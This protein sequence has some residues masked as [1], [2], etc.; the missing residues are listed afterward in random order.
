MSFKKRIILFTALLLFWFALSGAIDQR[1]ILLGSL[2]A[3]ASLL[4]YEWI[5][6]HSKIKPLP[7]MPSVRWL[8]LVQITI[9]AIITSTY[10]HIVRIFYGDDETVFLQI[11][12][13][14]NHPYVTTIIANVIT[15]TPGAVSVE[16]DG[17]ILK[18]LMFAPK[19]ENERGKIY[20]LIDDLQSVFGRCAS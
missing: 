15:L 20:Q 11:L 18:V 10:D 7:P 14:H 19:N 13:D 2:A 16:V 3:L 4:L 1:Q 5:L 12:L 6:S 9:V 17:N 8:K